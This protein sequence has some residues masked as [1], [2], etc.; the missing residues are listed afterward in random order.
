MIFELLRQFRNSLETLLV[1]IY[2]LGQVVRGSIFILSGTFSLY[3]MWKQFTLQSFS[4]LL[5]LMKRNQKKFC[6]SSLSRLPIEG[7]LIL[8]EFWLWKYRMWS[9]GKWMV[10]IN[11]GILFLIYSCV[12]KINV[13]VKE[14]SIS[15][16]IS[17]RNKSVN[18]VQMRTESICRLMDPES[19]H[20]AAKFILG[21]VT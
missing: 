3:L 7:K 11:I 20:T 12:R 16:L 2:T 19:Q 17:S 13:K 18:S 9:S 1:P 21:S 10:R 14:I 6:L 5:S 8:F 4:L 15:G